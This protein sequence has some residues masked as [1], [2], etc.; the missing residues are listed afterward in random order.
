L[1]IKNGKVTHNIKR[2]EV[3]CMEM[4]IRDNERIVEI[5]LTNLEKTNEKLKKS[6]QPIFDEY[7][8]KNTRSQFFNR[9]AEISQ[10]ARQDCYCTTE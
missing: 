10:T 3:S 6:L 1:R 4:N 5:W 9:A 8:Q 7:K 2:E